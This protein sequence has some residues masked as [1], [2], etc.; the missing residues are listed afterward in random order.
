MLQRLRLK[1]GISLGFPTAT[2]KLVSVSPGVYRRSDG[3][4]LIDPDEKVVDLPPGVYRQLDNTFRL[5][6]ADDTHV[7]TLT[8]REGVLDVRERQAAERERR[9][10]E[11]EAAATRKITEVDELQRTASDTL[12]ELRAFRAEVQDHPAPAAPVKPKPSDNPGGRPS[13]QDV[14]TAIKAL[15]PA[16]KEL[17]W[18][19][20][21]HLIKRCAYRQIW[22]DIH[23][24]TQPGRRPKTTT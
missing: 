23:G 15:G 10:T 22:E 24:V 2:G 11:R 9:A 14:R 21:R 17:N 6:T 16:N 8:A 18:T 12:A 1:S 7:E 3:T 19:K 5:I 13:E 4:Y 20:V